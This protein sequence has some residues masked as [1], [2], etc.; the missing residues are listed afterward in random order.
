MKHPTNDYYPS[1]AKLSTELCDS[2]Y[3]QDYYWFKYE[4]SVSH[5]DLR[6]GTMLAAVD[7]NL[8]S[9]PLLIFHPTSCSGL[10]LSDEMSLLQ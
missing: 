4:G 1:S 2:E 5:V 3:C 6:G 8:R 9:G 7:G 10:A